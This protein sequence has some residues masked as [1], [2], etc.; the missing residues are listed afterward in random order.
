[1]TNNLEDF[2][3]YLC[4]ELEILGESKKQDIV[5]AY[6]KIMIE[7]YML[8]L[9]RYDYLETDVWGCELQEAIDRFYKDLKK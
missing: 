7:D 6:G 1:M 5:R 8:W 9:D 4:S 3:D 2:W